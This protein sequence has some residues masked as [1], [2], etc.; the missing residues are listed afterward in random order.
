MNKRWIWV[1]SAALLSGLSVSAIASNQGMERHGG[2]RSHGQHASG[3]GTQAQLAQLETAL[4]LDDAQRPAW[5]AFGKD[6]QDIAQAREKQHEGMREAMKKNP[7]NTGVIERMDAMA[8]MLL[9]RQAN[10]ATLKQATQTFMGQLKPEQLT[11]FN[12][13]A[14][15]MLGAGQGHREGR[16]GDK[17]QR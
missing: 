2:H 17:K 14:S 10:L 8:Q 15:R 7:G 6:I 12:A 16:H 4:K 11:V 13:Q 1:L 5:Q 3:N 9:V